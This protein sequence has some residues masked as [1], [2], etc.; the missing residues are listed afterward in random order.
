MPRIEIQRL[1]EQLPTTTGQPRAST[2]GVDISQS[3]G[4]SLQQQG[5][6]L[7]NVGLKAARKIKVARDNEFLFLAYSLIL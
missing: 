3:L 2:A 7:T 5:D 6:V 4:R 1:R